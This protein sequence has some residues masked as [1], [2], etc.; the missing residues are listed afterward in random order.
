[1]LSRSA[2]RRS[3]THTLS[4][5]LALALPLAVTLS[6][7]AASAAEPAP[8]PAPVPVLGRPWQVVLPE[9]VGVRTGIPLQ[10][11]AL[12]GGGLA[13]TV[14]RD[15]SWGGV[16]GYSRS[17]AQQVASMKGGVAGGVAYESLWVAPAVDIFVKRRISLGV[18][19][20]FLW[21]R[22]LQA[23]GGSAG[24]SWTKGYS[25]AVAPRV[26]YVF[27]MGRG[28]SFWPRVS[29]GFS[30]TEQEQGST[31]QG[32]F[33][34]SASRSLMG[35]LDLGL[36]YHPIKHVMFKLA[37]QIGVGWTIFQSAAS[38]SFVV[39]GDGTWVRVGGEA[40]VGVVL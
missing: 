14:I 40:T 25:I 30:Y 26:G 31:S 32:L 38:N 19:A 3:R 27:P 2:L 8:D 4:V 29:V 15:I 13:G 39:S 20:G 10:F 7:R 21:A 35:G 23:S 9:L 24:L 1:M 18:S 37:P 34:G 22:Q 28:F 17:E 12:G 16:L 5:S 6:T 36:V 11:G 33:M